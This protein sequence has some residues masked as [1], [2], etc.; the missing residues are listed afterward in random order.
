MYLL[1]YGRYVRVR[2]ECRRGRE[3]PASST[4]LINSDKLKTSK[5]SRSAV[6]LRGNTSRRI[7]LH[8]SRVFCKPSGNIPFSNIAYGIAATIT[9]TWMRH[10]T[11]GWLSPDKTVLAV[12]RISIVDEP[13]PR[14]RRRRRRAGFPRAR[15]LR[16]RELFSR[17]TTRR[18]MRIISADDERAPE[19]MRTV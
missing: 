10:I 12:R 11:R 16:S 4:K 1:P 3:S 18:A 15:S 19:V 13:R 2:N 7:S 14:P 17:V 6:S 9:H 8:L 5:T